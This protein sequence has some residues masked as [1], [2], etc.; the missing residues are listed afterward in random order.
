MCILVTGEGRRCVYSGVEG[1]VWRRLRGKGVL[2]KCKKERIVRE[3]EIEQ[4]YRDVTWW[5]SR[6]N[7]SIRK[8][9]KGRLIR[10]RETGQVYKSMCFGVS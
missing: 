1:C 4:V 7:C 2:R 5:T 8:C 9:E 6:R 3:R 10:E